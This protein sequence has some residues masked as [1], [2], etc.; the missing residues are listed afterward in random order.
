MN[1]LGR[2]T[3]PGQWWTAG[4]SWT[5]TVLLVALWTNIV[6]VVLATRSVCPSCRPWLLA[7]WGYA[8]RAG[9]G[10]LFKFKLEKFKV[11]MVSGRGLGW[12]GG[13][14]DKLESVAG[15]S[16]RLSKEKIKQMVNGLG[17]CICGQT[18]ELNPADRILYSTRDIT[19]TVDCIPLIASK[20]I[21]AVFLLVLSI[22]L[23][24]S[25]RWY[26]KA[27]SYRKK[28]SNA[29]TPWFWT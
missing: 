17:G 1:D 20:Y 19:S 27:P 8:F 24:D 13:T 22:T 18:S 5:W 21:L 7:V 9:D 2:I 16:T 15:C 12:T 14:L 3:W 29:W 28:R 4:T 25:I 26:L 11:P 23:F 10:W 6:L